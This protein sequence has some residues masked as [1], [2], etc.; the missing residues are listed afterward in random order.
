LYQVPS[1]CGSDGV[2]LER[3]LIGPGGV[4]R[5]RTLR[6]PRGFAMLDA[7]RCCDWRKG[8][9]LRLGAVLFPSLRCYMKLLSRYK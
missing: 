1:N 2:G 7:A 6:V 4:T 8:G 5:G 9:G 3:F